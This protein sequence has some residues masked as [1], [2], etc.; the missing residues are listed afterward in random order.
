VFL[1]GTCIGFTRGP[2][3]IT[4]PEAEDPVLISFK[5]EAK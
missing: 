5:M 2:I 3:T 4:L 1:D